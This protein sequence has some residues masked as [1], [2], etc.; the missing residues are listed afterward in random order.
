MYKYNELPKRGSMENKKD[1]T[2]KKSYMKYS[3]DPKDFDPYAVNP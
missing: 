1:F 2:S 3:D